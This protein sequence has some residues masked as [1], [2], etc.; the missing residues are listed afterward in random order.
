MIR[1]E[2]RHGSAPVTAAVHIRRVDKGFNT[3]QGGQN[4][5]YVKAL[6]CP[7]GAGAN[8]KGERMSHIIDHIVI[9]VF[10]VAF[11]GLIYWGIW[12]EL[13]HSRYYGLDTITEVLEK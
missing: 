5:R 13:N 6:R 12:A 10:V 7:K 11:V 1:A 9:A 8:Q 4:A 2:I 3:N